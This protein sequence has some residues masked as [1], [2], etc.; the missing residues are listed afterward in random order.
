MT[1]LGRIRVLVV[2]ADVHVRQGL[3]RLLGLHAGIEVI[4]AAIS[5]RTAIPKVASYRPDCVLLGVDE[6]AID[7]LELLQHLQQS[8]ADTRRVVLAPTGAAPDL[9]QRL[10]QAGANEV[11]ARPTG[12]NDAAMERLGHDVLAPILRL[13]RPTRPAAPADGGAVRGPAGQAVAAIL[14]AGSPASPTPV[15]PPAASASPLAPTQAPPPS[16]LPRQPG[17][18]QVVGIGVSTGGPKALGELLP[19]LP[20]DFP[21]PILLVQ[22]MPPKFT[23]SL[24]ESLDRACK[25]RV[26]EASDGD[27]IERGRILIAPGGHHMKVVRTELGEFVRLT[28]DPPQCSCRPSVDYLFR[29]LAEIYGRSVLGVVLTGMGEDGW[30][31]SR[32]IHAAGGRIL[33]Q[34]Q[35]TATVWGMPR[36]PIEAGIATAMPLEHMADAIVQVVRGAACN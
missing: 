27:R 11:V 29:S 31:G 22:H 25:L 21:L 30:I 34:D 7:G 24:A 14:A 8:H 5:G 10:T 17:R 9:V 1:S 36:G 3:S 19:R 28:D 35:A 33:A 13:G 2:E 20:A 15:A 4:G 26:A 16:V 6:T 23:K 12:P 18:I 32:V